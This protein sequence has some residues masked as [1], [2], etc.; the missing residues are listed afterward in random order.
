MWYGGEAT[1]SCKLSPADV[2]QALSN[3]SFN[4][5]CVT[6]GSQIFIP[7]TVIPPLISSGDVPVVDCAEYQAKLEAAD[8][9]APVRQVTSFI[10]RMLVNRALF[11]AEWAEGLPRIQDRVVKYITKCG[12]LNCRP[13]GNFTEWS[14]QVDAD[15]DY[16]AC[17]A[18]PDEL[19][20]IPGSFLTAVGYCA[21]CFETLTSGGPPPT[22]PTCNSTFVGSCTNDTCYCKPEY[23]AVPP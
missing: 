1:S 10:S 8:W 22:R 19:Q 13:S 17:T 21:N 6:A 14:I 2:A 3:G 20:C 23:A 7:T 9:G 18:Q 12:F 15:S 16:T 11:P 4:E 5:T